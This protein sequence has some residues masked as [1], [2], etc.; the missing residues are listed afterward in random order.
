MKMHPKNTPITKNIV[1]FD[2]GF[3]QKLIPSLHKILNLNIFSRISANLLN[4]CGFYL[5][6]QSH[7]AREFREIPKKF[8]EVCKEILRYFPEYIRN[9]KFC[10]LVA[11]YS[12]HNSSVQDL[13]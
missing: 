12:L 4:Y 7:I 1:D 3:V 11:R 10:P 5:I 13:Q 2:E 6:W 8:V 9:S